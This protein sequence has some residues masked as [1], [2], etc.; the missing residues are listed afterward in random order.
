MTNDKYYGC[1][2]KISFTNP[3][4][5][6]RTHEVKIHVEDVE[7]IPIEFIEQW[8]Q[9]NNLHIEAMIEDW[10]KQNESNI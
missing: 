2:V 1:M 4:E 9:M 5:V 10:R 7:A 8:S 6:L 3:V